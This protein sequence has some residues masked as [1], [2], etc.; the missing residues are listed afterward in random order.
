MIQLPD[1][2][3]EG[4]VSVEAALAARRSV[5]RFLPEPLDL[6]EL[7][8]LLWAAQGVTHGEG[9]RTAPSAGATFPLETF[10]VAGAVEGLD[11]GVYRYLPEGHALEPVRAGDQRD[12]LRRDALA[13]PMLAQAPATIVLAAAYGRTSARYR[14]RA[15]MYVH[16]EAGHAAQSVCLM[17]VA[18]GLGT[19]C[20]GAFVDDAIHAAVGMRPD[21]RPVY[22]LPVGRPAG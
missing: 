7:A 10:A 5:R 22:L 11:P 4:P 13:Q 20:V 14:G 3:L 6:A 15:E 12:A 9:K 21:E 2:R 19:C 8:Q 17:A 1:P 18:L 16:E